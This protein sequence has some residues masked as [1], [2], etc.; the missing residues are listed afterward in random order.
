[1]H[2]S[3]SNFPRRRRRFFFRHTQIQQYF[4]RK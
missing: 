4:E 1:M 2:V 3:V